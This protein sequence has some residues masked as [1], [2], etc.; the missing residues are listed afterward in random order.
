[1]K[2]LTEPVKHTSAQLTELA[3]AIHAQR[4][5][6]VFLENVGNEEFARLDDMEK[7]WTVFD[8]VRSEFNLAHYM[9]NLA[10]SNISQR[11][12]GCLGVDMPEVFKA[13]NISAAEL[14][15]MTDNI[16]ERR[17]RPILISGA[18]GSGKST[19]GSY[20]LNEALKQGR[21][22]KLYDY[23]ENIIK[24]CHSFERDRT[25]YEA[26]VKEMCSHD[27][28][29]LDDCFMDKGIDY[30]STVLRDILNRCSEKYCT[31]II[32]SQTPT[33]DWY[34]HFDDPYGAE[35]VLDRTVKAA[36]YRVTLIGDSMR[37]GASTN[38]GAD[39]KSYSSKTA[40]KATADNTENTQSKE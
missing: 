35:S 17:C 15:M 10:A 22:C 40:A 38:I 27:A 28:I 11:I 4:I 25:A 13:N 23:S 34:A 24:L 33:D 8:I 21:L 30:E 3:A 2:N 12:L 31:V 5:C 19:V 32:S 29:M 9:D 1:M 26:A 39:P 7:F 18:A 37:S 20:L 6:R 14:R 36:P 16:V